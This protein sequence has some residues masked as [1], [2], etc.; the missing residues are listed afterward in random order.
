MEKRCEKI[1]MQNFIFENAMSSLCLDII[2]FQCNKS[3]FVR[4]NKLA[5]DS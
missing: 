5:I 3:H 2:L 1:D 4:P